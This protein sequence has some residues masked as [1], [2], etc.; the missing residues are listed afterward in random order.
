LEVAK[1]NFNIRYPRGIEDL[2][3]IINKGGYIGR[4]TVSMLTGN[5][6]AAEL[7]PN[8]K[9]TENTRGN[10]SKES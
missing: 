7:V 9:L 1:I 3:E 4:F 10:I 2:A 8:L 6:V 5:A